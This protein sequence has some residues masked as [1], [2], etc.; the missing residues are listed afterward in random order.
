MAQEPNQGDDLETTLK[1]IRESR[2]NTMRQLSESSAE[3]VSRSNKSTAKARAGYEKKQAAASRPVDPARSSN[4]SSQMAAFSRRPGE[5]VDVGDVEVG[6]LTPVTTLGDRAELRDSDDSALAT[7]M[8]GSNYQRVDRRADISDTQ[9]AQNA[10]WVR[11]IRA[12]RASEAATATP[13]PAPAPAPAPQVDRSSGFG[14]NPDATG[15]QLKRATQYSMTTGGPGPRRPVMANVHSSWYSKDEPTVSL[16]TARQS[17]TYGQRVNTAQ[18]A[19]AGESRTPTRESEIST[20]VNNPMAEMI[21]QT[22]D[23]VKRFANRENNPVSRSGAADIAF[24]KIALGD[25]SE[26]IEDADTRTSAQITALKSVGN[27]KYRQGT[28]LQIEPGLAGTE[29]KEHGR[30]HPQVR[31]KK[32]RKME[33]D[34]DGVGGKTFTQD[35]ERSYPKDTKYISKQAETKDGKIIEAVQPATGGGRSVTDIGRA[36]IESGGKG[37][38]THG[39]AVLEH[40]SEAHENYDHDALSYNAIATKLGISRQAA[41]R[42]VK[43]LEKSGHLGSAK[44]GSDGG[45]RT[46]ETDDRDTR[47]TIGSKQ[48]GAGTK[49]DPTTN[50]TAPDLLGRGVGTDFDPDAAGRVAERRDRKDKEN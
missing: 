24:R 3:A 25:A 26:P 46:S 6:D 31:K 11:N 49:N 12:N 19:R 33:G 22:T 20:N 27:E 17:P 37:L 35:L 38:K 28:I 41:Q 15:P 29:K 9:R 10:E 1:G 44:K 40:L 30:H 4:L 23:D 32:M 16:D 39:L 18:A 13:T 34:P 47:L 21:R 45:K 48:A 8:Y 14:I 5:R 43:T 2:D 50:K 42:A 36:A 7:Q